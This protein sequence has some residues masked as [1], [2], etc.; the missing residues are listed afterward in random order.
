MGASWSAEQIP[1]LDGK[2]A[3]VTGSNTGIGRITA[4]EMARKGC[5]VI[6]ACRSK[7]KTL[8]VVDEI[9]E[10]TKNDKVEFLELDLASLAS[11]ERFVANFKE[12]EL[13]LHIL[14]NN[15][16]V[17]A[18]PYTLT[19]D[20]VEMQFGTNHLGHFL[21]TN[22]LLDVLEKSAPS[23]IVN[24]SSEGHKLAPTG[25]VD[26]EFINDEE[27]YKPWIAYG[28]SKL[29]NV[30]FTLELAKR[31][32]D[33]NIYVN[34]LH[35]GFVATELMRHMTELYGSAAA[36][37]SK[38]ATVFAKSPEDGALTQLYLATSPDV[39]EQNIRGQYYVPTAKHSTTSRFGR[40][41]E[42]AAKLWEFS[43]RLIEEKLGK[44]GSS[45]K[46]DTN[47]EG[48]SEQQQPTEEEEGSKGK[49]KKD[50][51]TE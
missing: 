27:K 9:K 26:F 12:K 18:C 49:E 6:L 3:I 48:G 17:M 40:D 43:E 2:V 21:L 23:R 5:H 51:Q 13:P 25:G 11:V 32:K 4:L 20:G 50:H 30:L 28:R 46:T 37:L 16:G 35:T 10:A 24:V 15:A 36:W 39:E 44:E 38:V 34:V 19:A 33:K 14:V 41:E 47:K 22:G 8:P 31:L 42:L 45:S 1:S 29:C 7:D